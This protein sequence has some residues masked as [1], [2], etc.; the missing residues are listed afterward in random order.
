MDKGW[1][2][3]FRWKR[4]PVRLHWSLPFGAWMLSGFRIEPILWL[5]ASLVVLV[6]EF[7]HA[8]VVRA[9]RQSV[10]SIDVH[11]FGGLCRWYGNATPIQRAAIAWGGVWAQ[12]VLLAATLAWFAVMGGPETRVGALFE[13]AFVYSN[14]WLM[15]LNLMPSPA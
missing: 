8:I 6:H 5:A 14:L 3:L 4:I 12:M 9:A 7:G 2:T 11:G 15:A 10:V 1:F 13:Y